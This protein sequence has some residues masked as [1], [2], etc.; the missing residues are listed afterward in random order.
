M[1]TTCSSPLAARTLP[2][3]VELNAT[4]LYP[5]LA[6]KLDRASQAAIGSEVK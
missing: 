1:T 4:D 2:A 3:P 5:F 6:K